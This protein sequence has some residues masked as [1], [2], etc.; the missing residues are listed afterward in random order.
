MSKQAEQA[1]QANHFHSLHIKGNPVVIFNIWDAGSALAVANAGAKAIATGSA[2]VAES[3]GFADGENIPFEL[4]LDNIKRIINAVDLPVSM[5]LEGAYGTTPEQ[6]ATTVTQAIKSGVIGFNFED[7]IINGEGLH[8][9]KTQSERIAAAR[10]ASDQINIPAFINARTD[11]F[12]KTT[13]DK[14]DQALL[15]NAIERAHAYEQ[16][17]A[18]G[19]FAPGL[20]NEDLIEQLCAATALPVNII[21]LPH[22]PPKTRLIELGV[23]RISYGPVP[24]RKMIQALQ[25]AA[26]NAFS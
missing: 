15:N 5:D 22:V 4:A 26:T 8:N 23:A 12:L 18:S 21:A 17:G 6:V 20:A 13:V 2:P 14:H 7:Q 9:I 11:L 24:Y 16:A 25:T 3:Q 10:A 19:F 1:E